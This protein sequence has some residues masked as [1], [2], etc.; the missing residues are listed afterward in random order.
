MVVKSLVLLL[1]IRNITTCI[2]LLNKFNILSDDVHILNDLANSKFSHIQSHYNVRYK[3]SE[4]FLVV[5]GQ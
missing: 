2:P 3:Y 4:L 1:N 5:I